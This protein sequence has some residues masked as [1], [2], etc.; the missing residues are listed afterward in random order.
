VQH[1]EGAINM[2]PYNNGT[3][4]KPEQQRQNTK[5][6]TRASFPR[7]SCG[8]A[9]PET[10]S[11]IDTAQASSAAEFGSELCICAQGLFRALTVN[12]NLDVHDVISISPNGLLIM[13]LTKDTYET[14]GLTGSRCSSDP[15]RY[16][17]T[18]Y[19]L[20]HPVVQIDVAD[21]DFKPGT[22]LYDRFLWSCK[23][24]IIEQFRWCMSLTNIEFFVTGLP[25]EIKLPESLNLTLI[26]VPMEAVIDIREDVWVPE[27]AAV[28]MMKTNVNGNDQEFV[29]EFM[30][31]VGLACIESPRL[32]GN[33][34]PDPFIAVY[35]PPEP[36]K[37]QSLASV[38]LT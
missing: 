3:Q 17:T 10:Q 26:R 2:L 1:P 37:V 15:N 18:T 23:H 25:C 4:Q 22:A 20:F 28:N 35:Q 16:N 24:V 14:A 11:Q 31:W 38:K 19:S 30:E 32:L 8:S 9:E 29:Q 33:D 34:K 6:I 7:C 12:N 5:P 27:M 13:E 21:A 36:S